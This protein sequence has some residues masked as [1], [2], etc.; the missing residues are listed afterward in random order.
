MLSNVYNTITIQDASYFTNLVNI[1]A[2]TLSHSLGLVLQ[3]L[4]T[5]VSVGGDV[6]SL[7]GRHITLLQHLPHSSLV[8][9]ACVFEENVLKEATSLG[10]GENLGTWWGVGQTLDLLGGGDDGLLL[11][12]LLL[13]LNLN[14]LLSRRDGSFDDLFCNDGGCFSF[15][16]LSLDL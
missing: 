4:L 11:L 16:L 1:F 7:S 14:L 10:N 15:F 3:F 9:L 2:V 6:I 13:G 12:L 5:K 8:V